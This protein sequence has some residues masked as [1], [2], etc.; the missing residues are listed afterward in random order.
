MHYEEPFKIFF[1]GQQKDWDDIYYVCW[2]NQMYGAFQ[3]LQFFDPENKL[4]KQAHIWGR[5]VI[6]RVF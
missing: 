6:L 2:F 3:G 5:W 1:E 4:W